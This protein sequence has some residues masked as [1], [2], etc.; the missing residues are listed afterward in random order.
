MRSEKLHLAN[1]IGNHMDGADYVY[2]VSYDGIKVKDFSQLRNKLAAVGANC[3]VLKN[4][5]I[6]KSAELRGIAPL[7]GLTLKGAS[8]MVSGKGDASEVA[9]ILREFGKT[10]DKVAPK[11]GYLDG[12][13]LTPSDVEVIASLPSKDAMRAQLLGTLQGVPRGLACLLNAKA[14]SIL[15]VLNAYKDKL[16]N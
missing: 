14:A 16:D 5:M 11:G 10:N 2:F 7:A 1:Y 9:K 6:K 3:H 8:A 12:A 15:N 4:R 13:L